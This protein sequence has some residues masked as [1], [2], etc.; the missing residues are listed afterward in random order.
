MVRLRRGSGTAQYPISF[1][2]VDI[3]VLQTA[4]SKIYGRYTDHVKNSDIVD[5][6][7][8]HVYILSHNVCLWI[9]LT[10]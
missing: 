1:P 6:T 10:D 5:V 9:M 8:V 2:P 7:Y 3:F 4:P